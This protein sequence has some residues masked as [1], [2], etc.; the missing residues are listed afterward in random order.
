MTGD[1]RRPDL[2]RTLA[3][4]AVAVAL[5]LGWEII[6]RALDVAWYL[7]PKPSEILLSLVRHRTIL[8]GALLVTMRTTVQA[9]LAASF[10]GILIASVFVQSRTIEATFFPYAVML[11][12]TPIVAIA[13]LVIIWVHDTQLALT[14]CAT[15]VAIFPIIANTT[16]GLRSVDPGLADYFRMNR[17]SRWQVLWRL[18]LPSA[19]PY[20]LAGLRIASGLALIGAVVAEYVA[21]QSGRN[22]GLAFQI[23]QAGWQLDIPLMFA[24]LLVLDL[25]G[26]VL[27]VAMAIVTRL[28][29]A[30]WHESALPTS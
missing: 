16:Q 27:Y 1:T 13:P 30:G 24:A 17:A 3:P 20:V 11:Q 8:W 4:L 19:L 2:A 9:F 28:A 23:L 7:V 29:L 21:G 18:L 5:V 14:I 25:A 15:L 6:C 26:V 12:V 10:V 22:A